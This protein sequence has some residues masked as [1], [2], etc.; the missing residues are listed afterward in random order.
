MVNVMENVS[1][2][3]QDEIIDRQHQDE[4]VAQTLVVKYLRIFRM[5]DDEIA[6]T[7]GHYLNRHNWTEKQQEALTEKL[8]DIED[9]YKHEFKDEFMLDFAALGRAE[10]D[11][12]L[13]ELAALGV[14]DELLTY[15]DS[16][17]LEDLPT[18]LILDKKSYPLIPFMDSVW[19]V[20]WE[21]M[22]PL[23]ATAFTT[24]TSMGQIL[25]F[26]FN[27]SDLT[28]PAMKTAENALQMRVFSAV[29]YVVN[30]SRQML[31]ADNDNL[32]AGYM[33]N[34]IM[35]TRTCVICGDLHG[36][37][38]STDERVLKTTL[39]TWAYPPLHRRCR[40]VLVP[41]FKRWEKIP[42]GEDMPKDVRVLFDGKLPQ[43]ETYAEWF[44][45]QSKADKM[46]I[47]GKRR[48]E[49]Y[50]NGEV[51]ISE[52]TRNGRILTLKELN[53]FLGKG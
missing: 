1:T 47:L 52:F 38:R 21:I 28:E 27:S 13:K 16:F 30:Q 25:D 20:R 50:V 9:N 49:M 23:V 22:M 29:D 12:I 11:Y 53:A 33:W 39:P 36:K 44:E 26:L 41:V 4:D 17:S 40:C 43:E 14:P 10:A 48:Y 34:A 8:R 15:L 7:L 45:K 46:R 2:I 31:Y 19:D 32:I 24:E 6:A 5:A 37:V 3:L 18:P 35:D 51:T 42:G